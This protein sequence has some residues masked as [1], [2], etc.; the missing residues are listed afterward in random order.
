MR[1]MCLS[2]MQY[3]LNV[4][5]C[6]EITAFDVSSSEQR[7]ERSLSFDDLY[8]LAPAQVRGGS[9]DADIFRAHGCMIHCMPSFLALD[10]FIM[11]WGEKKV[12]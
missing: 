1:V 10:N 12:S 11:V 7:R 4:D 2:N 5:F 6:S 3:D 9:S 8:A